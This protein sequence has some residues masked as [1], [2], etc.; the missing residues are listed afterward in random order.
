M[1]VRQWKVGPHHIYESLNMLIW[2]CLKTTV[3][4]LI[5]ILMRT[6]LRPE[7]KQGCYSLLILTGE[8]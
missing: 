6:S 5:K 2:V 3:D 7:N 4:P 1:K 8:E